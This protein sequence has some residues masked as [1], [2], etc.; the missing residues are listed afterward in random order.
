MSKRITCVII[1][2]IFVAMFISLFYRESNM[3]SRNILKLKAKHRPL[4]T[5]SMASARN[6]VSFEHKTYITERTGQPD[7]KVTHRVLSQ[8]NIILVVAYMRS[9]S[10]M[11]ASFLEANPGTFYRFE[12]LRGVYNKFKETKA[13]KTTQLKYSKGSRT[14]MKTEMANV[15]MKELQAWLTCN[16]TSLSMETILDRGYTLHERDSCTKDKRTYRNKTSIQSRQD[17]IKQCVR[18]L[19]KDCVKSPSKVL[20]FIRLFVQ[21]AA[22]FLPS[23]PNMKIIHLV[24]DPRGIISSRDRVGFHYTKK[25]KHSKFVQGYSIEFILDKESVPTV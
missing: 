18:N 15:M 2:C 4:R 11:T 22:Y 17:Q 16:L 13:N 23:F 8:K 19:V 14:F 9:G 21:D 25:W 20:K 1:I 10:T 24:R 7:I 5:N 6:P 12:P 3:T